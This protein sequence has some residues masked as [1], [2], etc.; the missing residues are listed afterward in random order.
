[1]AVNRKRPSFIFFF[2]NFSKSFSEI[3]ELFAFALAF[4]SV[5]SVLPV[6]TTL[7]LGAVGSSDGTSAEN[8]VLPSL[9]ACLLAH[10]FVGFFVDLLVRPAPGLLNGLLGLVVFR[11]IRRVWVNIS[12]P[13]T[14]LQLEVELEA[15]LAVDRDAAFLA[16][17]PETVFNALARANAVVPLH[18]AGALAGAALEPLL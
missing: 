18:V 14:S 7:C 8:V 4:G 11:Q 6:A 5:P 3:Y 10:A 12:L 1:M 2:V 17:R 16:A 15:V 13:H 9:T